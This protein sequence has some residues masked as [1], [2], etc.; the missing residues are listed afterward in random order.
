MLRPEEAE[1]RLAK[2]RSKSHAK[3]RLAAS[4]ALPARLAQI[5]RALLGRDPAGKPIA[6]WTKREKALSSAIDQLTS[7]PAPERGRVFAALFPRLATHLEA[8]WLLLARL[9]Y[10]VDYTRK[11]FRAP[12]NPEVVRRARRE[13]L[14][15][16]LD[17]LE[18]YD[19]DIAW[20]AAWAP[21]LG[22]SGGDSLGILL[23]AALDAG[24][25]EG[26]NVFTILRESATNE[27]EIGRMGRH[28]T[29]A[30]LVAS[31]PEAWEFIEKMLLAAQRQEGL[32]QVILE[33]IDEAHPEAFRR[34]LR[35]ILEHNL[36]RF[37]AT[38]RAADVWFSLNWDSA[39]PGAIKSALQTVLRFLEDRT[40]RDEALR[41]ASGETLYLALWSL[42]FEDATRAVA[43]A[44]ELLKSPEVERRFVATFFLS[45]LGL[46]E[47]RE[48]LRSAVHDPDLRIAVRAWEAA[49]FVEDDFDVEERKSPPELFDLTT[50]LLQRL[51]RKRETLPAL[52]WPWATTEVSRQQIA[53]QLVHQLGDRPPSVLIPWLG[54]LTS[55]DRM[56][57][58]EKLG[59]QK[60]LTGPTRDALFTLVGDRDEYVREEA[61]KAIRK[62][63]VTE[64]DAVRLEGFLTRK[65]SGVRQA[66]LALLKK[67]KTPGALASVDRLVASK[68]ALQRLGGLELMQLL[69]ES[70]R[71]VAE[72][73]ERAERFQASRSGEDPDEQDHLDA[74]LDT[75]REIPT[76]DNAL[77]LLDP[78][79]RTPPQS[80]GVRSQKTRV[81][82]LSSAAVACLQ[83]L[84]ALVEK[85]QETPVVLP[86]G[87]E[88]GEE[89]GE[90]EQL[91]GN[92]S[93]WEFPEPYHSDL[94]T[95]EE[96]QR[97]P[98]LAVWEEWYA[99]RP[100]K[101]RD[102]DELE[103]VRAW[104]W[105]EIDDKEWKSRTRRFG[106]GWADYLQFALGEHELPRLMHADI[107]E[108][109]LTW[110][111]VLHPPEKG[112]DFLCDALETS[113]ALVPE[114]QLG[115]VYDMENWQKRQKDW[116]FNNPLVVQPGNLT[117]VRTLWPGRWQPE[118]SLRMWRLLHWQ[119]Q[120][121]PGVG[122]VRPELEYLL[123]G[124]AAG[125]A[126][127]ADVF[128][129]LLGPGQ[130]DFSD[131]HIVS[132][133]Q[134]KEREQTPGLVPLIEQIGERILQIELKRGETPTAASRPALALG[135]L[136][137]LDTLFRLLERLGRKAFA[138]TSDEGRTEVL[139]HLIEIT[140]PRP[141]D[142]PA[143]FAKK[144]KGLSRERL[145]ELAFLAPQWLPHVEQT[146]G[147]NGLQE[148]VYWY[149]AHMPGGR[150]GAWSEDV[151]FD[152]EEFEGIEG[153]PPS[154]PQDPWEKIIRER[155]PL[156]AH[157][158]D[159]GAV[160]V[161][162][163]HKAF[164][165]LGRQRWEALGA[166]CK[167]GCLGRGYKKALLLSDVLRGRAKKR[168]LI[169]GVR[170]KRLKE[171]VRLLGL[172]PLPEGAQRQADLLN[173]YRALQEY[174]RYAKSLGPM[175]REDALRAAQIGL[176]NLA[177]T[178]GYADPIRLE[179]AME[180][181]EVA[182]LAAGPV[183]VTHQG[184][185]V[186]LTLDA[187]AQAQL[188]V[189]RGDKTLKAIP[190]AVRKNP[191][192]AALAD[193]RTELKR[194]ASRVKQS[195][196][197]AMI[198]GDTFTGME[199]RELFTHPVLAPV[200]SRLILL[201]EGIRGY[202]VGGGK[203]LRDHAG[204]IE[205]IKPDEQ[206]R[207]AH[208]HDLFRAGDWPSWQHECF[209]SERIQPFKQ[210]FRELYLL[211]EQERKDGTLSNRYAGQ[212]VNPAQAIALLGNR[213]WS[214]R[215]EISRTFH[216]AGLTAHLL[217]R[218]H[219]W[220]P[221]EVEGWTLDAVRFT[222]KGEW[223][224][225]PLTEVPP[226]L[227]SE[228]MR[229]LDL[230]VSVAHRG[231][232]D[233]ETSASTVDMRAALVQETCALL[234]IE[235]FRI[236]GTHALIDGR[237]GKYTIHLGSGVVH[238]QPGGSI[239][240]VPVHAQHRGR[241]FLP[242]ADDD[243]RTAEVISKVLLLARD[244]EIQDPTILE[245]LR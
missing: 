14:T 173:R 79:K 41:S 94:L 96:R 167:A 164:E 235:N 75:Q 149:L 26:D 238:R 239:C 241:L 148:G 91:F 198:R 120:P 46:P 61:R 177:R 53:S 161:G 181:H 97:F 233:P 18:G 221:L 28:V 130:E 150:R 166:A 106:S 6:N 74:I 163:F 206:L 210:V 195:L 51:S 153:L 174:R 214:V 23:A 116:R 9:P 209:T 49:T 183:A 228:V 224:P 15:S 8:A 13:W 242:F 45:Q 77:G 112:F 54:D 109:I 192:I 40:A 169:D 102:R 35:L 127:A 33:S 240:I 71:C 27:H 151:D 21:F 143:A 86:E 30:F 176:E 119:D 207:L 62:C 111:L 154:E 88:N 138:Q 66:V 180:A 55:W 32:R 57:V 52:V 230:V 104:L 7:L 139:T 134:A 243:P 34:M 200:L 73:R 144:A 89:G 184:V 95:D 81:A 56:E 211:T 63:E 43:P 203:G 157:E 5:T 219:G 92:L 90:A 124:F 60:E 194:Q 187:N 117:M 137:G 244:N 202:P 147:W 2:A 205:P 162:W 20:C 225:L 182:D 223:D 220:T 115:R 10:L 83:A 84:D 19:P 189:Q 204:Q 133:P 216:E 64:A 22:W 11:G 213:N 17:D 136:F 47:A 208:P 129:H 31:R 121:R 78:A 227:F 87:E 191:R 201:G 145:L 38:V 1:K 114:E 179:W 135:S 185:T 99:N 48:A 172:L 132:M 199:L 72:C 69:V 24:G 140:W 3:Q 50:G 80:P 158:R 105:A 110:L 126:N 101:Q 16:L 234:R 100:K 175:S 131:L 12:S 113:F 197:T 25:E 93:P 82:L 4:G 67:Q 168:D 156:A 98:L 118:H 232:V 107:V 122:R 36:L 59:E 193:R 128:D 226:R 123:A 108:R 196:E 146:L 42:A 58:A 190:S 245:Q 152:A 29:R 229:D 76:L 39:S 142:N 160:D 186:T 236:Q 217:L 65:V 178:A 37:S 212:Q 159:E 155:T 44:A 68:K 237:L 103:L 70:R 218:H 125:E 165:P 215:E 222:R 170:H 171:S 188:T 85:H 141:D 231:G